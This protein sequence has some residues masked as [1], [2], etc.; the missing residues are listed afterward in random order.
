MYMLNE[1]ITWYVN[2]ISR[3]LLFKKKKKKKGQQD[4]MFFR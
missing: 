3:K 4:E 1:R 2:Y